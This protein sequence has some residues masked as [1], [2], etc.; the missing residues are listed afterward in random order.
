MTLPNPTMDQTPLLIWKREI[1]EL[2]N[3]RQRVTQQQSQE[4]AQSHTWEVAWG[5]ATAS[6]TK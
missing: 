1:E 4:A 5:S 3:Q 2:R 6:V